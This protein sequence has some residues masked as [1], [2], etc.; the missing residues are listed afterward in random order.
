MSASKQ[1][2]DRYLPSGR[3]TSASLY[4]T[5]RYG[6]SQYI[7]LGLLFGPLKGSIAPFIEIPAATARR[8]P[9][10]IPLL[11]LAPHLV[12]VHNIVRS[13]GRGNIA[14]RF[15]TQDL[16]KWDRH[17]RAPLIARQMFFGTPFLGVVGSTLPLEFP[18]LK[19][20]ALSLPTT[21]ITR[22]LVEFVLRRT[23]TVE[24]DPSTLALLT[25]SVGIERPLPFGGG[26]AAGTSGYAQ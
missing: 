13:L 7:G 19:A 4:Q 10:A 6:H 1:P 15:R 9:P 12:Q 8:S 3:Q 5:A 17:Q 26:V 2:L 23:D 11:A 18:A 22:F 24:I 14:G 25:A 16:V 20:G 21:A